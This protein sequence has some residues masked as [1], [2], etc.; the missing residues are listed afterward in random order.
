MWKRA[1]NSSLVAIFRARQFI[2]RFIESHIHLQVK[3]REQLEQSFREALK[4]ASLNSS[5]ISH[6]KVSLAEGSISSK[7]IRCSLVV[8]TIFWDSQ[9]LAHY[10]FANVLLNFRQEVGLMLL[11]EGHCGGRVN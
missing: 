7:R 8:L 11:V 5:L 10:L 1:L 3:S 9:A 6:L 4:K 2:T